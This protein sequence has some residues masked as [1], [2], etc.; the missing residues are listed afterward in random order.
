[1]SDEGGDVREKV[2][3]R[4]NDEG[5][6]R[7]KDETLNQQLQKS[8]ILTRRNGVRRK[9]DLLSITCQF[10]DFTEHVSGISRE[11]LPKFQDFILF[12]FSLNY[13]ILFRIT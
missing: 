4:S 11:S 5:M 1:M 7:L 13:F 9:L 3:A 12:Y 10:M 6:N 2:L 8:I